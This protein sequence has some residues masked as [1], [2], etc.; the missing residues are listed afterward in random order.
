M[1]IIY[2]EYSK[3]KVIN[4]INNYRL[5]NLNE[6][7]NFK[8]KDLGILDFRNPSVISYETRVMY[9]NLREYKG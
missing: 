1:Q 7:I 8:P 4:F 2:D 5:Y 3:N 6:K 9:E